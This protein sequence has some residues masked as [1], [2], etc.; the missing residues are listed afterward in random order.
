MFVLF[1][2]E[3]P[4]NRFKM[5]CFDSIGWYMAVMPCLDQFTLFWW[6]GYSFPLVYMA[7]ICLIY[8]F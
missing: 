6:V 3:S 4:L 1:Y 7:V 2:Q 8:Q 5:A